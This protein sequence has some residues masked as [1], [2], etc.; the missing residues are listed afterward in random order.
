M[1]DTNN[2][3]FRICDGTL[4]KYCGEETDIVIPDGIYRIGKRAFAGKTEILSVTIPCGVTE[5]GQDAFRNCWKLKNI[6]V[7]P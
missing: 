6:R 1:N 3:A 4:E 7:L 5:I 2:E